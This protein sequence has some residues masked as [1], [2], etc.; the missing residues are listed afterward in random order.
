VVHPDPKRALPEFLKPVKIPRNGTPLAN[1]LLI[2]MGVVLG[3]GGTWTVIRSGLL[4]NFFSEHG[5][6]AQQS[7]GGIGGPNDDG[8]VNHR[9]EG[10]SNSP[11]TPAWTSRSP[12][13]ITLAMA[14]RIRDRAT[15][16]KMLRQTGAQ[17][18][19]RD[20]AESLRE[21]LSITRTQDR[22]DYYRGLVGSWS[23]IDPEAALDHI[24]HDF[25]TGLL[26]T[27]LISLAVNKW[28]A[29]NPR[30]AWVWTEKRLSG[31]LRE[32]S[33]ADLMIGWTRRNPALAADWLSDSGI[34][35]RLLLTTVG[36]TW[37]E[38]DP[39]SAADW[40]A[41]LPSE[42]TR[43]ASNIAVAAEWARQ[44]P[45][46]A[47]DYY[48][49]EITGTEG[50]DLATV[51]ADIWGTTDPAAA[52]TWVEQLPL[53]QVRDQAASTLATIWATRDIE[54]A[55][56]WS[57]TIADP[58]TRSQVISHLGTTW[59]ALEP[60]DA[61]AWLSTLPAQEAQTGLVGAFNSW[62][63]VDPRGMRDWIE[64]TDQSVISDLGRRSLA[65]ILSQDD[66]LT[67]LDL[68]MG[69]GSSIE[70]T[71]AVSRY[72]RYWRKIDDTSAQEWYGAMEPS[73]PPDLRDRLQKDLAAQLAP[74]P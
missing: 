47:V 20:V 56:A 73:L 32:Q 26:Q 55:V 46:I 65:D 67:S 68:A 38:Q 70:Q 3:V 64:N 22:L 42:S 51:L 66:I 54:A 49:P 11:E 6:L 58:S 16:S 44:D 50:V 35:S 28:G 5:N 1:T 63:A 10:P 41:S 18:A 37:A 14:L 8:A 72:F 27:E 9:T 34:Q 61:I 69:I 45:A 53:G 30:D 43:K 59:G 4:P 52:A 57:D 15:R 12:K 40:A 24:Q 74:R 62:G 17:S 39:R 7:G 60:D 25:S 48:A 13:P 19:S 71:D 2:I 33:Q 23:E 36:T 21:G 31:P 29:D